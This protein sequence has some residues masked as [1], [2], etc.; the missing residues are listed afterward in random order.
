MTEKNIIHL[1]C[2]CIEILDYNHIVG[3]PAF[4]RKHNDFVDIVSQ[5]RCE[6]GE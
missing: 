4:C 2:G 1:T 5:S 3:S 6:R